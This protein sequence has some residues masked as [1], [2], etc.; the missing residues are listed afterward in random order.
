MPLACWLQQWIVHPEAS[1]FA[2][3]EACVGCYSLLYS[4]RK[5][6]YGYVTAVEHTHT[7]TNMLVVHLCVT[8]VCIVFLP[9]IYHHTIFLRGKAGIHKWMGLFNIYTFTWERKCIH[10]LGLD[11]FFFPLDLWDNLP[12]KLPFMAQF[13]RDQHYAHTM[14]RCT[15]KTQ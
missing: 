3:I 8:T 15:F 1:D 6:Y 11:R 12:N 10:P 7:Y 13:S 5:R 9:D 4:G 2:H 14:Y